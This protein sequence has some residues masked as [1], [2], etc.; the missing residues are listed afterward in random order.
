MHLITIQIL[1]CDIMIMILLECQ[2]Q[3]DG[4]ST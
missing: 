1:F 3:S 4:T 2:V